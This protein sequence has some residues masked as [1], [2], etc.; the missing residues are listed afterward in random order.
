MYS[1]TAKKVLMATSRCDHSSEYKE[2]HVN[3]S[4][5]VPGHPNKSPDVIPFACNCQLS[6]SS[7]KKKDL[8]NLCEDGIIPAEL[9]AWFKAL[10]TSSRAHDLLPEPTQDDDLEDDDN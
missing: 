7:A 10:P 2:V 5:G 4:K 9:H 3:M 8:I 6:I 1:S